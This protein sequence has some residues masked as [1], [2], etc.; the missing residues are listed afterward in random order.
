[1]SNKDNKY[2]FKKL[3]EE[4]KIAIPIIQREYAQGRNTPRA[5]KVRKEFIA[6]LKKHLKENSLHLDFIFGI[7]KDDGKEVFTLE[8]EKQ[9]IRLI[10]E[11]K[12]QGVR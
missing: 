9:K 3:L 10:V 7:V 4:Y 8:N 11:R 2:T 1:M 6:T 5:R 12:E